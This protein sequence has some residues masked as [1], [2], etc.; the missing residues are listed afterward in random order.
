MTGLLARPI[1]LALLCSTAWVGAAAESVGNDD[2]QALVR[3][4]I[5]K[6][7]AA[8]L[9]DKAA[10]EGDPN[11]AVAVV[12]E[13]VSPHVDATRSGRLILGKHWRTATPE[14]RQQ[15]IDLYRRLLL[16]TYAIHVSDYTDVGV[17]YLATMPLGE[18]GKDAVVR[19][20]VMRPGKDAAN[21]DYRMT[22]S[23]SGWKVYDVV[24]NGVSIVVSFRSG[25]DAEIQQFGIDGLITRLAERVQRPLTN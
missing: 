1:L 5:E 13:I 17:D 16:R 8:V 18:E 24:A 4:T 6:L 2:P 10:I 22:R 15:F 9:R 12:D 14:Q 11:R 21:V 20:R 23:G 7:R 19:T 25:V 3:D